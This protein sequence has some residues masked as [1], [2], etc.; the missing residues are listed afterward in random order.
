MPT[1]HSLRHKLDWLVKTTGRD[2]AEIVSEAVE[3]GL[4]QLYRKCI[5]E[6]YLIGRL[7]RDEAVEDLGEDAV[8]DLDY[9][10]S[11]VERDVEWGLQP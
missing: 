5:A 1:D 4:S 3:Q 6:A 10:Q 11:A 2:E 7:A 8:E 9:A